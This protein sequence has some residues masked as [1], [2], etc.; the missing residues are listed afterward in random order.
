M[1][2]SLVFMRVIARHYNVRL[3][4]HTT[5]NINNSMSTAAVFS[6]IEET[7]DTTWH[8]ACYVIYQNYNSRQI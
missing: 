5:L 4:D 3:T 1:E 8:P 2:V 7:F 6:D